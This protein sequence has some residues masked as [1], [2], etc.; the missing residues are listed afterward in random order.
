ML[1][2]PSYT[3]KVSKV[4][5]NGT[6]DNLKVSF[7]SWKRLFCA[8]CIRHRASLTH[9]RVQC[10]RVPLWLIPLTRVQGCCGVL[11]ITSY[12]ARVAA[13]ARPSTSACLSQPPPTTH[14]RYTMY[15]I[16][17]TIVGSRTLLFNLRAGL[18]RSLYVGG[19]RPCT[20]L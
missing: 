3:K 4:R 20:P 9:S 15:N 7:R 8:L 6:F 12:S 2:F 19:V 13:R 10:C 16:C 1:T 14:C 5:S 18:V 11:Q 17:I